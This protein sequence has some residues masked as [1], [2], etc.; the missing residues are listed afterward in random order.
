MIRI[1]LVD[2]TTGT[3]HVDLLV[4]P[5][6]N[7][8]GFTCVP[9]GILPLCDVMRLSQK[10]KAGRRC[11]EMGNYVWYRLRKTPTGKHKSPMSSQQ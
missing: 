8:K 7:D 2:Y 10:V 9:D 5:V 11:G 1:N 4:V 6:T 3:K